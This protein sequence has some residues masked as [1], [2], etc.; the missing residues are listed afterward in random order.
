MSHSLLR[1]AMPSFAMT[2]LGYKYRSRRGGFVAGYF[3]HQSAEG[4]VRFADDFAPL[5]VILAR[6]TGGGG[7]VSCVDRVV[8]VFCDTA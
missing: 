7:A 3:F 5:V 4:K 6:F 2:P 1:Y 8:P